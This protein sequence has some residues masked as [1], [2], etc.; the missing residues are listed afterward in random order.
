MVQ[1]QKAALWSG[2]KKL[3]HLVDI[4]AFEAEQLTGQAAKK[5]PQRG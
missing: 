5:V 4:C 2:T 3:V 1:T